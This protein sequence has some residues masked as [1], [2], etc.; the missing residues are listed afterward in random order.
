M[1]DL[2]RNVLCGNGTETTKRGEM[3]AATDG[4]SDIHEKMDREGSESA[5]VEPID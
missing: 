3:P 4:G 2:E 5:V 1:G